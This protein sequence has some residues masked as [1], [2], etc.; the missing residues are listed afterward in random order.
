MVDETLYGQI[1]T[2]YG[3]YRALVDSGE[4]RRDDKIEVYN[5]GSFGKKPAK[6]REWVVIDTKFVKRGGT[7]RNALG[8]LV[9][10][11]WRV[12]GAQGSVQPLEGRL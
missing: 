6:G 8:L 9:D 4:L 11:S 12:T 3:S 2:G 1:R 5:N 7:S 10:A